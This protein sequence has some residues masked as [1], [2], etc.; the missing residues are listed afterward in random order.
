MNNPA[1]QQRPARS[2]RIV[3]AVAIGA[4]MGFAVGS[5]SYLLLEPWLEAQSG[6]LR[7]MQGFAFNLVP[8]L[9]VIGGLLGAWWALRQRRP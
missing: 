4:I 2:L 9:T 1:P 3:V 7:E 5:G 6:P 8:G